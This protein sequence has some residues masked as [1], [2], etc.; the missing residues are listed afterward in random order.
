MNN[1]KHSLKITS[2][3]TTPVTITNESIYELD[4]YKTLNDLVPSLKHYYT[5]RTLTGQYLTLSTGNKSQS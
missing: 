3:V 5:L 4:T 2:T 1:G